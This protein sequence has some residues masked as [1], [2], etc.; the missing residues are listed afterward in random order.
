MTREELIVDVARDHCCDGK[1]CEYEAKGRP[2]LV[3][4]IDL[5]RAERALALAG[6]AAMRVVEDLRTS[7]HVVAMPADMDEV[8]GFTSGVVRGADHT[9]AALREL[10]GVSA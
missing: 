2:C 4:S 5:A 1:P 3:D 7:P 9:I 6:T 8:D 10:F